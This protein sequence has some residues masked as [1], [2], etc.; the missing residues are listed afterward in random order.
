MSYQFR[1][2]LF[3]HFIDRDTSDGL[4][5]LRFPRGNH[6]EARHPRLASGHRSDFGALDGRCPPPDH[7]HGRRF[8]GDSA[9]LLIGKKSILFESQSWNQG[10]LWCVDDNGLYLFASQNSPSSSAGCGVIPFVDPSFPQA[11]PPQGGDCPSLPG[12]C[13]VCQDQGERHR[14]LGRDILQGIFR[15]EGHANSFQDH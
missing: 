4:P 6:R 14:G 11:R 8:F 13:F 5:G 1:N 15:T 3:A 12:R 9:D 2:V 10:L 7:F